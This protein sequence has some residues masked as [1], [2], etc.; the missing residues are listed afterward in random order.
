V[1][2]KQ[3][4]PL[5]LYLRMDGLDDR[6][7]VITERYADLHR[8]AALRAAQEEIVELSDRLAE[9]KREFDVKANDL[10]RWSTRRRR[11]SNEADV[12]RA[13]YLA[14]TREAREAARREATEAERE[15]RR[16]EARKKRRDKRIQAIKDG[17]Y[18]PSNRSS[19]RDL[20]ENNL[21]V[22]AMA[23]DALVMQGK[24]TPSYRKRAFD[25]RLDL[26][27]IMTDAATGKA[28]R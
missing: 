1:T 10:K 3:T 20:D 9:I 11:S 21:M 24:A 4:D 19:Q 14:R 26:A 8:E 17:D 23:L 5:W 12:E 2:I 22:C 6:L 28:S 27:R 16:A 7:L 13:A 18:G 15:E 25:Q